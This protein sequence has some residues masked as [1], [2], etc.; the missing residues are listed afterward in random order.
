MTAGSR[1]TVCG[2]PSATMRPSAITTTQSAM[3]RTMC[4]SCS[5]NSTVMPSSF[6]SRMWSSSDWVSA[7]F[8]PA[9]GSSSMTSVGLGHERARHLEQLALTAGEAGGEVVGL[10]VELELREQAHGALL[11]LVVLLAPDRGDQAL[12]EAL[13][14]LPRRTEL[15]VVEHGQQAERLGQLEG[16]D[17]AHARHLVGGH[18]A[19]A[20]VPSKLHVAAVRLVEAGEQVE[21]RRLAGTVRADQRGDRAARDLEVLD[22]DGGEAAERAADVVGDEDRVDLRARRARRRRCAGR[23]SSATSDGRRRWCRLGADAPCGTHLTKVSSFLLP[24]M[25]CGMKIT[26]SMSATPTRMKR[27]VPAWI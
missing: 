4:M 23:W 6:R 1:M 9:I 21:Q 27:S 10:G 7:G 16:A 3:W 2:S 17:Q 15:H 20:S 8:T 18:A 14:A 22:V 11:D 5:T 25:P 13:A 26:S 24:R 19:T 12:P